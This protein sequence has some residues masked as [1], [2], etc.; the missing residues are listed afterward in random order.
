MVIHYMDESPASQHQAKRLSADTEALALAHFQWQE[1]M[2][3]T[4]K[5]L[6]K[7]EIEVKKDRQWY[8]GTQW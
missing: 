5:I 2:K 7:H 8:I 3:R 1:C 4:K 6:D